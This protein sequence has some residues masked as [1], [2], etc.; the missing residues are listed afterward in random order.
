MQKRKRERA[1]FYLFTIK[2]IIA[3]RMY[4]RNNGS[5]INPKKEPTPFSARD[6]SPGVVTWLSV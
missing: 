4:S 1:H 6:A 3:K 5:C 2:A